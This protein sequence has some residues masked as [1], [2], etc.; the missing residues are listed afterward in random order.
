MESSSQGKK[1][2]SS[3]M[4][5]TSV[6]RVVPSPLNIYLLLGEKGDIVATDILKGLSPRETSGLACHSQQ[7]ARALKLLAG[8]AWERVS[9]D[10]L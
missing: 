2:G 7:R 1:S 5:L 10:A 4:T 9:L 3:V 6:G 8:A